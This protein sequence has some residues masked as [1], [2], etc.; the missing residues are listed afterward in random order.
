MD[1]LAEALDDY[2]AEFG[3]FTEDELRAQVEADRRNAIWINPEEPRSG[4]A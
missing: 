2:Q 1:A 4:V 3:E